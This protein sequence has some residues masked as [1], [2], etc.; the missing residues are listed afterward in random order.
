[1]SSIYDAL[2]K[3]GKKNETVS[4]LGLSSQGISLEWKIVMIVLGFFLYSL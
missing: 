4:A 3:A 1:M 2:L